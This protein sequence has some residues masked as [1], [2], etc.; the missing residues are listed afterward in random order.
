[1]DPRGKRGVGA[2]RPPAVVLFVAVGL[3]MFVAAGPQAAWAADGVEPIGISMPAQARGGADVAVGDT[4]LSQI[5]NPATLSLQP[6]EHI[7]FDVT[8]ELFMPRTRWTNPIN[9]T[10]S[11]VRHI[12]IGHAGLSFRRTG[13]ITFGV[14]FESKAQFASR[15]RIRPWLLS[16]RR[17]TIDADMR[18]FSLSFNAAWAATEKLSIGAGVRVEGATSSF[19]TINGPVWADFGR[20]RAIGAGFQLGVH[21]RL[22]DTVAVGLAYRSPTWFQDLTGD[23]STAT[24]AG[25]SRGATLAFLPIN[26]GTG[27]IDNVRLPQRLAAGVAWE[28][29]EWLLLVTEAR[30][31]NY[32][33]STLNEGTFRFAGPIEWHVDS[34]V[35]YRDQWAVMAGAEFKLDEHWRLGTGYHYATNPVHRSELVPTAAM[36]AQHHATIGLR[37]EAERWWAGIGYVLGFHNDLSSTWRSGVPLGLDFSRGEIHQTQHS[38]VVGFGLSW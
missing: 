13:P 17:R 36:I 35:G 4:A 1:M 21:Y 38:V 23:D 12:P 19:K 10:R 7:R 33:A 2:W 18:E 9:D 15:F 28:A 11:N 3:V 8:G 27:T 26:L 32:S 37:Y 31:I 5:D 20:G 24:L 22:L 30:W 34:P 29:T 16:A 14:A 25:E 6:A